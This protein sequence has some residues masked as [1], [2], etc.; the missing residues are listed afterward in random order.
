MYKTIAEIK[1]SNRSWNIQILKSEYSNNEFYEIDI[2]DGYSTIFRELCTKEDLQKIV[3]MLNVAINHQEYDSL[4]DS[5][6]K[7]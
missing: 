2:F 7:V 5:N 1:N 3:Y 6:E 4:E